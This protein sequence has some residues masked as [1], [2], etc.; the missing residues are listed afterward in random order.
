VETHVP[1]DTKAH[2]LD[3]MNTQV[4]EVETYNQRAN[5]LHFQGKPTLPFSIN[6]HLPLVIPLL[7]IIVIEAF[8]QIM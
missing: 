4:P 1:E 5:S 6:T 8:I 2:V 7:K 3:R